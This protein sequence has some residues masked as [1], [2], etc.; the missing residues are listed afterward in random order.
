MALTRTDVG[1]YESKAAI[2]TAA[3]TTPSFTPPA[4]SL[5]VI[6]V[7]FVGTAITG[8]LGTP[9]IEGGGLAF[10][11][12]STAFVSPAWA[13]K[14]A[15]FTAPVGGSPAPMT[16]TVDDDN[17]QNI[18]GYTLS[19]V[20]FTGVDGTTPVAG[21]VT[22]GSTNI[23]DGEE[24][25]TLA[26][27]PAAEDVT[28]SWVAVDGEPGPPKPTM[29]AGWT[30]IHEGKTAGEGGLFAM[31]REASTSTTVTLSDSWGGSVFYKASMISL[32]IKA[33]KGSNVVELG[34][35]TETSTAQAFT[36]KKTAPMAQVATTSLAMAIA[37]RKVKELGRAGD[38]AA[39]MTIAPRK[40]VSLGQVAENDV[41]QGM[42]SRKRTTIG[43]VAEGDLATGMTSR[44]GVSLGRASE[45][46]TAQ[47]MTSRKR[48]VIGQVAELASAR[49]LSVRRTF[50]LGRAGDVAAAQAFTARRAKV[51][52]QVAE[53]DLAIAVDLTR[54]LQVGQVTDLA[55][56]LGLAPRKSKVLGQVAELGTARTIVPLRILVLDRVAELDFAGAIALPLPPTP[57][58]DTPF[59]AICLSAEETSALVVSSLIRGAIALGVEWTGAVLVRPDAHGAIALGH[60]RS[61][62]GLGVEETGA[63]AL[64]LEE[65]SAQRV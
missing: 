25:Q 41:A 13:I 34:R 17:N 59:G 18:G 8:D 5:L 63:I 52:G 10:T 12:R 57:D 26:A 49:A 43:Q 50:S 31:R 38:V 1:L 20:A 62:L 56:A 45:A 46:A 2:G 22:S 14:L 32:I 55:S 53:T 39:A 37:P 33:G 44:K 47:G 11:S 64:G 6:A 36:S 61:A 65:R 54:A 3:F 30:K 58:L 19:V 60:S 35:V 4:N 29:A 7:G 51:L 15:V 23:G 9:T 42:T 21:A 48:Q 27:T 40:R 28:M 16:L 24:K